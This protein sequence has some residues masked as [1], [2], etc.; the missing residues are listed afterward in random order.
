M[1]FM[2]VLAFFTN[3]KGKSQRPPSL[4]AQRKLFISAPGKE[5]ERLLVV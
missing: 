1:W 2:N 3:Q 5:V 4:L